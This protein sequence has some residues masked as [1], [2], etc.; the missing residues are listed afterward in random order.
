MDR[1]CQPGGV[2]D[3][4]QGARETS[5]RTRTLVGLVLVL[6]V[7]GVS[8]DRWQA[9]R[10]RRALLDAV[11]RGEQVI[12]RSAASLRGLGTYV[13]PL[14]S[15]PEAPEAAR[16]WALSV[17]S[18]DAARWQPRVQSRRAEVLDV[19]LAPWHYSLRTAREAY[20]HRLSAW[21]DSLAEVERGPQ[22]PGDGG[23]AVRAAAEQARRALLAAGADAGRVDEALGRREARSGARR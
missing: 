23:R 15:N 3:E 10:E 9:D 12:D 4:V 13:A 5:R 11:V 1:P 8:A 2:V 21:K 20:A 18:D 19:D 6:L 16:A 22:A 17:L 14:T 7:V